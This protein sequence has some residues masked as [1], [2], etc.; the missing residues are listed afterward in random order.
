[1]VD[2]LVEALLLVLWSCLDEG[3]VESA[4]LWLYIPTDVRLVRPSSSSG[5]SVFADSQYF[6]AIGSMLPPFWF[7]QEI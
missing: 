5:S 1:M 2:S 6:G 7:S 3:V 4:A